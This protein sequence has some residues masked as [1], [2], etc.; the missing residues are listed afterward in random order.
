MSNYPKKGDIITLDFDPQSG[1]E[2]AKRRP[3][4]VI[5]ESPFSELGLVVVC[6]IT[7]T[8]PRH[9]FHLKLPV[10]RL[11]NTTGSV[12][13]EQVKSFD[14]KARKWSLVEKCPKDFVS[15]TINTVR[16]FLKP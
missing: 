1:H 12:M 2:Q 9:L 6:P 11:K 7:S 4:L 5:S 8:K 14:Y 3:A 13:T 15:L 10:A 16:E